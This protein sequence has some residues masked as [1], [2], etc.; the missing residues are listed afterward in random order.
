MV[1]ISKV[2]SAPL[3]INNLRYLDLPSIFPKELLSH[4]FIISSNIISLQVNNLYHNTTLHVKGQK[5]QTVGSFIKMQDECHYMDLFIC[6]YKKNLRL[7]W[8]LAITMEAV[9]D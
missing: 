6:V 2:N 4:G 9:R 8:F 5:K 7:W 1:L 3:E